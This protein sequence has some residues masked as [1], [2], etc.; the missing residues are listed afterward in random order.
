MKNKSMFQ[1]VVEQLK[2]IKITNNKRTNFILKLIW[3]IIFC[4]VVFLSFQM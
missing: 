3:L 4:I 1:D 2:E